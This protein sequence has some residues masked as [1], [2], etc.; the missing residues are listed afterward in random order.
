K[1]SII[2][3]ITNG[4][5]GAIKYILEQIKNELKINNPKIVLTGGEADLIKITLD[6]NQI[7]DKNFTLKGFKMIYDLNKKEK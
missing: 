6:K 3:G 4:F 2:S 5:K 1:T 7:M